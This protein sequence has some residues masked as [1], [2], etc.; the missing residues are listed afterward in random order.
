MKTVGE[1]LKLSAA[2]LEEKDVLRPRVS[3]EYLLASI[4]K[5]KRLE[6]Y[7]QYDRPLLE[8]EVN[9]YRD[10]IKRRSRGEPIEYLIGEIEFAGCKLTITSDVLIPRP[11]TE[12]LLDLACKQITPA[13]GQTALDLCTGS[14]CLAIGLKK[15]HP[16]LKV[17]AVDLSE[18]ALNL[19]RQNAQQNDCAIDFVESDLLKNV[20]GTFDY[21]FCNPPY[22]SSKEYELISREVRDFEPSVALLGGSTGLEFYERLARELP[23]Y[24]RTGAQLFFEIGATQG[25]AVTKIFNRDSRILNDWAGHPRFFFCGNNINNVLK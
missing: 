15:R 10:L 13:P 9:A 5:L 8:T 11:E 3:A 25:E 2:F 12:I 16:D 20:E 19:A 1:L 22:L 7:M 21:V 14:G 17:V 6:L 18:K 4:L 23:S 24:L